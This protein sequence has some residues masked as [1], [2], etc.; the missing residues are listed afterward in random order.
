MT[1]AH[2][3]RALLKSSDITKREIAQLPRVT[4]RYLG[5]SGPR[6]HGRVHD[7]LGRRAIHQRSMRQQ[8]REAERAFARSMATRDIKAFGDLLADDAV[9]FGRDGADHGKAAVIAGWKPLFE[10][11]AAPFS[12]EPETVEVLASGTL[13][14]SSGPVK[15]PSGKQTG[16]FNSIWRREAGGSGRSCSTKGARCATARPV[17]DL[18]CAGSHAP[19]R[20]SRRR[21]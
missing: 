5:L 16:V 19:T 18:G 14:L 3:E 9:F 21:H 10:G 11:P 6:S 17:P 4:M 20:T 15:D 7:Q 2:T 8:V 1:Q 12:W 13:G